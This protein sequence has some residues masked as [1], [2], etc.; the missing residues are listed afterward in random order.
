MR[1]VFFYSF[2]LMFIL[3]IT[4]CL[5]LS[6][7]VSP[8]TDLSPESGSTILDSEV[9]FN[10][11]G[12]R[13]QKY[14]A[15][16]DLYMG[17]SEASLTAVATNLS[18]SRKSVAIDYN[19]HYYWK[20][21]ARNE[22]ARAE[23]EILDFY[24]CNGEIINPA[25]A[26][27]ATGVATDCYLNWEIDLPEGA[28]VSYSLFFAEG[29][30]PLLAEEGLTESSFDPQ[31]LKKGTKYSWKVVAKTDNKSV[32]SPVWNF[33]TVPPVIIHSPVNLSP[34]NSATDVDWDITLSWDGNENTEGIYYDIY[35]GE[36]ELPGIYRIG[37]DA[38]EITI[39]D[40]KRGETYYWQIIA[41]DEP[42]FRAT[43]SKFD[44]KELE[45]VALMRKEGAAKE[46][47]LWSFTTKENS[48]PVFVACYPEA[49]AINVNPQDILSWEF[50]DPDGDELVYDIYFEN[51]I[52]PRIRIMGTGDIEYS[53]YMW[54]LENFYW[55]VVARDSHGG[56]ASS[57]LKSF[58]TG[59]ITGSILWQRCLGGSKEDSL[60]SIQQ[61]SDGGYILAGGTASSD[62]DVLGNNKC[63]NVWIVKLNTNGEIDWQKCFGGSFGSIALYIQQ[64]SDGGYI[65]AGVTYSND[66]DVSGNH[67]SIDTWI[68]KLNSS[69][70]ISWQKCIGGSDWDEV[71]SIQQTSDDGYIIC[72]HT[73]SKD[74]DFSDHHGGVNDGWIVKLSSTGNFEWK[75]CLG[76]SSDDFL[77]S[78]QQ[79]S[80]EAYIVAGFSDSNDGDV[81]GNHG[82]GDAWILKLD[83]YGEII[84]QK[85]L[86]GSSSD[87]AFSIQ[88]TSDGGY[89]FG[90]GTRSNDGD[91]SG[92]LA[93]AE[94][95]WIV[96]LDST[97]NIVWQRCM[98]GSSM[99]NVIIAQQISNGG[100]IITSSTTSNNGDV[101][102]SH[103]DYDGFIV[104]LDN[105]GNVVW[106]R[107]FGG[108]NEDWICSIQQT[109]DG[110]YIMSGSTTSNNGDVFGNHGG[111]DA[112]IIKTLP[113]DN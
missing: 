57:D 65:I 62:G 35:F 2:V 24:T 80:D 14:P 90:G 36:S 81:S 84:W 92:I 97:G 28:E 48:V 8:L 38:T 17:T 82:Y 103:G 51:D 11:G 19:E 37:H 111:K 110:G 76:G 18:T 73:K 10:W 20:V 79:I 52:D 21:I 58:S 104:E 50:Y 75:K 42:Y 25:P 83:L 41:T 15:V 1:K 60:V 22:Y 54:G 98:G 40:L 102:D 39:S 85:C 61:T 53:P 23:S 93:G 5:N 29:N 72:G 106:K 26:N 89:I 69:G 31:E 86:G 112:W 107:C 13:G 96:K 56:E 47:E 33:T 94:D 4:S 46:G 64:T 74:G 101:S 87:S 68:L 77:M 43:D 100:Y 113:D 7:T 12:G 88:Q 34:T 66:G 27:N 109:S 55:K 63:D 108:S 9:A 70:I 6:D 49:Y 3:S 44:T 32:E 99:E 16:Y 59:S 105:A 91:V 67:G 95:S 78:V 71:H 30:L 45:S